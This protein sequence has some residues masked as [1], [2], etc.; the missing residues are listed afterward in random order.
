VIDFVDNAV[1]LGNPTVENQV[2]AGS[3]EAYG[4]ELLAEKKQGRLT[5]WLSYTWSKTYRTIARQV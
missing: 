5:G 2:R 3:G 4:A 1:L